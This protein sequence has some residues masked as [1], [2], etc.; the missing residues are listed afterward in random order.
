MEP[1]HDF[2]ELLESFNAHDVKAVV[3]GAYALAYHGIPRTTG[4]L[5]LLIDPSPE[6]AERVVRALEDFGFGSLGL[7]SADFQKPDMVIQLG[8]SP[9]RVDLLTSITGVTWAEVWAGRVTD[10]FG[11]VPAAFLGRDELRK[12]K[13]AIGRHKDLADLEALGDD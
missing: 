1:P 9:V 12:N 2:C 4:D 7:T 6:N 10:A 13:R 11:G 8:H 3:V 5:D